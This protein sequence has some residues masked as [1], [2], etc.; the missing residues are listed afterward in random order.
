P[1]LLAWLARD[2]SNH[3]YD[4]RRLIRQIAKSTSYQLDS[5][6][7][8]SAGQP[9]L[10]FFFARAL[11]KPLSAETFTRSLRVALGHENPNDETLRNHFAKI[12]P[13]LFADNFSPSVQQT[14]FLTNAPFFDKIISE[15]PLLSHLQNMKN[16]QA[17]VHETFQSILSRAPEPIELERSLSF[18]DPNDKS[19]IQQFVWALL[20]SAE[21]RFT[22]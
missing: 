2:F 10:D 8:P 22:N 18:V 17:L 4:L 9:P 15:G 19:S 5:R 21:F 3:H 1:E 6:P 11:D 14:M 12:L 20:T 7:A 16:P 13:E